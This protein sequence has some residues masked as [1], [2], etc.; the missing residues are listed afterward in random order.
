MA[1]GY[2]KVQVFENDSYIPIDKA[3]VTI[4]PVG[5]EQR[6]SDTIQTNSSGVTDVVE[7]EA[8]P[9]EFSQRPSD[10]V[11]YSFSDVMVEAEGY[12]PQLIKGVQIYPEI[13]ALQQIY[14]RGDKGL[15]RQNETIIIIQPNVL[16][17]N[18]PAKIPE[19]PIKPM[20]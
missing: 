20:P 2:L 9:I 14:L 18:Y 15:T 16:V 11:P 7:L 5:A 17:G 3:K 12:A 10:K 1:T 4:T 19:E 6:A 8:P 13:T